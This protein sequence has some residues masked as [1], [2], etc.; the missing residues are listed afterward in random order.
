M[1]RNADNVEDFKYKT[2]YMFAEDEYKSFKTQIKKVQEQRTEEFDSST[3]SVEKMEGNN[4]LISLEKDGKKCV[5]SLH[6]EIPHEK[7]K[8]LGC[9]REVKL[10]H[11]SIVYID[12]WNSMICAIIRHDFYVNF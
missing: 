3:I 10:T 1:E 4:H 8:K 6:L 5:I 2:R 7:A 12:F 11:E 9:S